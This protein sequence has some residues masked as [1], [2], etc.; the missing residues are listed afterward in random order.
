MAAHDRHVPVALLPGRARRGLGQA[1]LGPTHRGQVCHDGHQIAPGPGLER[2]ADPFG[3]LVEREPALDHMLP[4]L[5]H[6]PIPIGVGYPLPGGLWSFGRRW[7]ALRYGQVHHGR[8]FALF[9]LV[10]G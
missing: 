8:Q 9:R 4:E 10:G 6:R 1:L 5:G 2:R 7:W 3:E